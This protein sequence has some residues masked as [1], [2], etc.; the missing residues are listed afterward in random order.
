M[1]QARI[2]SYADAHRYRVGTH[3]EA[4]PVNRPRCPVHTYHLDGAMRF[5]QPAGTDAYYEPNS[6]G[7]AADNAAYV[8]P[9]LELGGAAARYNH[10]LDN[11]DY[12]QAGDLFRL[13]SEDQKTVLADNI[14][15]AMGGVPEAIIGR[16]LKHFYAANQDYGERVAKQLAV[17]AGGCTQVA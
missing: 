9:A 3:Y 6:M 1:L 14:A 17:N 5:D 15:A 11:D 12:T 8:E 2:F 4:L 7:G 16:Q 13:M 10:R